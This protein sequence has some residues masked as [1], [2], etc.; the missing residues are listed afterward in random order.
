MQYVLTE[1]MLADRRPVGQA[2][3]PR[4][5]GSLFVAQL[6]SSV[7]IGLGALFLIVP[8]IYFAAR[9]F[10][11]T[12]HLIE[13]GLGSSEALRESWD[14]SAPSQLA[15]FLATVLVM[16]PMI[17]QLVLIFGAEFVD[18]GIEPTAAVILTNVLSGLSSV[19]GWVLAAAAYRKVVPMA[20]Q[21]NE[22]FA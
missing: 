12:P 11:M 9:W 14:A 7:M 5:Y 18:L 20:E 17:P 3:L 16:I 21:F 13:R 1:R 22:V 8:G 15:F 4:R 19:L 2:A 10:T 6:M